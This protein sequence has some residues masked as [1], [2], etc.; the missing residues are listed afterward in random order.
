MYY[1]TNYFGDDTPERKYITVFGKY[2]GFYVLEETTEHVDYDT[3]SETT[4]FSGETRISPGNIVTLSQTGKQYI[5]RQRRVQNFPGWLYQ[6][7]SFVFFGTQHEQYYVLD[8]NRAAW[9]RQHE[10]TNLEGWFVNQ[11]FIPIFGIFID[12]TRTDPRDYDIVFFE[13]Q[14]QVR[15]PNLDFANATKIDGIDNVYHEINYCVEQV[16]PTVIDDSQYITIQFTMNKTYTNQK[17]EIKPLI[18]VPVANQITLDERGTGKVV[19]N[20]AL[21]YGTTISF[22]VYPSYIS[23][24]RVTIDINQPQSIKID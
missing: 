23:A 15:N 10:F 12:Q 4:L 18:N 2:V 20:K 13:Q 24:G 11:N 14:N 16:T 9:Y 17:V 8:Y 3:I 1:I 7:G 21:L 6:P 5:I 22:D 19:Y